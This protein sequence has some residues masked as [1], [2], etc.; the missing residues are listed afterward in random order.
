LK[1][2]GFDRGNA[3]GHRPRPPER[4]VGRLLSGSGEAL[5]AAKHGLIVDD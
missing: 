4:Q 1:A 5:H 2:Q 3:F